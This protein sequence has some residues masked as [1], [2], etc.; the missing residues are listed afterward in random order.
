MP[1]WSVQGEAGQAAV[2]NIAYA[3]I[4]DCGT[5]DVV[6]GRQDGS[7]EVFSYDAMTNKPMKRF[8][9]SLGESITG[10]DVGHITRETVK[11]IAICTFDGKVLSLLDAGAYE[12]DPRAKEGRRKRM[13]EVRGE[14]E[15]LQ[16]KEEEEK[17]R[18]VQT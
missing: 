8:S 9:S 5:N 18:E 2:S 13:Q 14:L 3:D 6:V 4:Y 10:V 15:E 1:I 17:L 7:I 12:Q 11:G 16:K